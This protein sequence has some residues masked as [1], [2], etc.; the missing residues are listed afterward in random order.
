VSG[1][2]DIAEMNDVV[3][4]NITT[5]IVGSITPIESTYNERYKIG[6]GDAV[7]GIELPLR[8]SH[9]GDTIR[10][11]CTSRFAWSSEGRPATKTSLEIPPDTDIECEI[12]ILKHVKAEHMTTLDNVELRKEC[13]NRYCTPI[14][15]YHPM[16]S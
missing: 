15:I 2:G 4:C 7:P 9:V 5:Y 11:K 14:I 6:E 12:E 13:G 10:I 1:S 16:H 8:H 3:H